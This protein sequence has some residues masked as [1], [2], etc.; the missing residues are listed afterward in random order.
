M[1][2]VAVTNL[3]SF[4]QLASVVIEDGEESYTANLCQRCY[5]K[6][7]PAKGG[8]R[9]WRRRLIVEGCGECW[10]KTSTYKEC[11]NLSSER[12]KAQKFRDEAKKEKQEGIQGQWQRESPAKEYLEQVKCCKGTDCTPGM[13]KQAFFTLK[14]GDC[15][16]Y[17]SI[18]KVQAKATEWAL[19]RIREAFEKVAKDEAR[20]LSIVHQIM[21]RSTD[22]LRRIIAPV[23]GQGGVTLSCL[24]P[25][26]NSFPLEDYI[27]W[28]S[29]GKKHSRWLCAICGEK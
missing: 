22:Y 6:K 14:G 26:C 25:H 2:I 10:R 21:L 8:A 13:M 24:C 12:F 27:W 11:G 15:R 28:V 3:L 5:N 23:G 9:S 1:T 16:E 19:E 20:R 4:W 18:F 17:K 29:A 7:L